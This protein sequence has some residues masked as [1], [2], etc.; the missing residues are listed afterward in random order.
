MDGSLSLSLSLS[1][2]SIDTYACTQ[3]D[4]HPYDNITTD[5]NNNAQSNDDTDIGNDA[6][7][8]HINIQ[9]KSL[10]SI[11]VS[12]NKE[13]YTCLQIH[14][15]HMYVCM[16]A[17]MHVCMYAYVSMY[18]CTQMYMSMPVSM[19]MYVHR[20]KSIYT[21]EYKYVF[22]VYAYAQVYYTFFW[23]V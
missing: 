8:C 1:L 17:R 9:T 22:Y 13:L 20:Y 2:S 10:E 21:Y 12:T 23:I 7:L 15:Q 5:R 19:S 3:E 6:G 4:M 11:S 16:Y 18:A 14:T